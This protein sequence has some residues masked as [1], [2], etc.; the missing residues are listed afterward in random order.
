MSLADS[1]R[2]DPAQASDAICNALRQRSG[3]RR[4]RF[5]AAR[6]ANGGAK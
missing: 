2:L 5:V 6:R 4:A 3:E 1:L